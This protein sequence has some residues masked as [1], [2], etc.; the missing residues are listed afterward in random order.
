MQKNLEKAFEIVQSILV[1][2]FKLDKTLI[3]KEALLGDELGLD[4]V[5][6]LDA[7]GLAEKKANVKIL[8]DGSFRAK[9]PLTVGD[10][11]QIIGDRL[12]NK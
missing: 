8:E 5:D 12:K 1:E 11:V 4:S 9:W 2:T 7:V 3:K 6:L 10:L